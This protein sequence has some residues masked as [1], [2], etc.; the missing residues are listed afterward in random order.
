MSLIGAFEDT[1][2]RSPSNDTERG[3]SDLQGVI[4]RTGYR[5]RASLLYSCGILNK[6]V[7]QTDV[8]GVLG[9]DI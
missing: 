7:E 5:N 6:E 8:G 3:I 4:F 1:G 2:D 9:Q